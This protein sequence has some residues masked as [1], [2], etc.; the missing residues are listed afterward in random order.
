MS[1][2]TASNDWSHHSWFEGAKDGVDHV[3]IHLS[4]ELLEND[5]VI[6]FPVSL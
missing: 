3:V 1:V 4:L 5:I 2:W 6:E